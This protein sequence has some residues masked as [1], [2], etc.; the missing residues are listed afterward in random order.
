MIATLISIVLMPG[1][2]LDHAFEQ[3]KSTPEMR[4]EDAYKWLY[5]ATL[6]GEHAVT[7]EDGPRLWL[8]REWTTL[9]LPMKG[10]KEIVPLSPDGKVVRINLRPYKARG[11]DMEMLLWAFVLSAEK[12]KAEKSNFIKSWN[13]LRNR[14]PTNTHTYLTKKEWDRLDKDNSQ[15]GYSAI[16][17]SLVYK[18]K[19]KPAYRVVFREMIS[20]R[21]AI[22]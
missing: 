16:D 6:G 9:E 2:I 19:Y 1:S 20:T 22:D 18:S 7:S 12:F 8:D 11:G 4:I 10:E 13:G 5:H 3:W 21:S 14:L 17:H 15:R